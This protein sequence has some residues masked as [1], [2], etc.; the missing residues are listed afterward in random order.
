MKLALANKPAT[1]FK[2]P[3]GIRLVRVDAKSGTRPGPARGRPHHPGSVQA[4][5]RAAG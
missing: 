2:V 5:H 3:A 1:P 4:G